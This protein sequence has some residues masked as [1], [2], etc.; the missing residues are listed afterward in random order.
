MIVSG[1]LSSTTFT[2]AGNVFPTGITVMVSGKV[3]S[4]SAA[5]QF[6]YST[7]WYIILNN[8]M[9]S[10]NNIQQASV[11]SGVSTMDV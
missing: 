1:S 3:L 10:W 11:T 9:C 2:I 5:G 4:V 7:K 8:C 6:A